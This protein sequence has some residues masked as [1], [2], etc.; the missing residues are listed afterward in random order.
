MGILQVKQSK[1]ILSKET[2]M[3][4][5]Q[6]LILAGVLAARTQAWATDY[7]WTQ[8]TAGEKVVGL[9]ATGM[10]IPEAGAMK[11]QSANT[12]GRIVAVLK[13][14]GD[15]V[16]PGDPL[17][18]INDAEAESLAEEI[19]I[20]KKNGVKE[21]ID[22]ALMRQKELGVNVEH[23]QYEI[24]SYFSGVILQN[25]VSSGIIYNQGQPLLNIL[26]MKKLTVELDIAERYI[27]QLH[28]GQ[29]VSFQLADDPQT[30]YK[31]TIDVIVPTVDPNMR[32]TIVRLKPMAL[33]DDVNLSELVY[34]TVETG[35][36]EP[37][38]EI[39]TTAIVF[40]KDVQYVLKGDEKN[41][42]AV[43]V[44]IVNET[45][46]TSDVRPVTPGDLKVGDSICSDG[47]ILL[48]S[49]VNGIYGGSGS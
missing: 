12:Q 43:P 24:V 17:Y 45:D 7:Q 36:V 25:L 21:L 6:F 10:I 39:P 46:T 13:K 30:T 38:L 2:T 41:P 49:K 16:K 28:V 22:A 48:F 18:L 40:R 23:G 44:Q 14:E 9:E 4:T 19:R 31:S 33:P 5:M 34:G 37:V 29:T 1:F 27:S 35:G 42:V 8:V 15:T 32:T 11:S 3:K 26:D 20:A 47:A